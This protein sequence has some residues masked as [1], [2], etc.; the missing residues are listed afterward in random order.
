MR[1]PTWYYQGSSVVLTNGNEDSKKTPAKTGVFFEELIFIIRHHFLHPLGSSMI[2][3][4]TC[5]LNEK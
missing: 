2:A 5:L 4:V 1:P 3:F